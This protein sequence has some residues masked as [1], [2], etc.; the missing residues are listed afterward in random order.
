MPEHVHL[1]LL[2]KEG[3]TI[4]AILTTIK[5]SVSN[6]ALGWLKREAPGFLDQLEDVQPNGDRHYRF[7]QRGGGY[8]RNLRSLR[9]VHEK[10]RYIHENPVRRGLAQRPA[11]WTWS[12]ALAWE[13]GGNEPLAIDRHSVPPLTI[14]DDNQGA[15]LMH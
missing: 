1:L 7:W 9:D 4:S 11:D 5:K 13:T 10:I 12:S 15:S 3:A 14:L 6:R 8:D 2:P